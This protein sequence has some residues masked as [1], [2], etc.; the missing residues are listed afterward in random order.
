MTSDGRK[1]VNDG[2]A[3]RAARE[4]A[5]QHRRIVEATRLLL[6]S[7]DVDSIRVADIADGAGCSTATIHNHFPNALPGIL[8]AISEDI[9]QTAFKQFEKISKGFSGIEL[10]RSYFKTVGEHIC[11]QSDV[12]VPSIAISVDLASQGSWFDR[13]IFSDCEELFKKAKETEQINGSHNEL[14]RLTHT[15]FQ[16]ALYSWALGSVDSE[17]F[18]RMSTESVDFAVS[19]SRSAA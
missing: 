17:E 9:I 19:S 7:N 14:A 13:K 1:T 4:R 3:V 11:E 6:A 8:A 10:V 16:G 2:R 18:L 15:F 12:A 5:K